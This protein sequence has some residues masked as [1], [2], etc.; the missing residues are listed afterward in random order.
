MSQD[1]FSTI[2]VATSGTALAAILND[3]KDALVSGL[4]GTSR[5]TELDPG[6]MWVDTTLDPASWSLKLWSGASDIEIV[7]I[8]LTNGVASSTL[9]VDAFSVRKISADSVGAIMNLVK[10]RVASNGQVLSGDV[11]G[12]VRVVG[13]TNTS[14]DP[15]VAKI[16]WT[17]GENQTSTTF[18][19]T[20]SFYSTPA[21]TNTLVEHL[22]FAAGQIESVVAH[23]IN[24]LVLA[25]QDVATTATINQ[26]SATKT[27][28]E[29]TGSTATEIRGLNSG[30]ASKVVTIHARTTG[31]G[32]LTFKH[33]NASATA[34]DRFTLPGA[35]DLVV[36]PQASVTFIY[37]TTDSRWKVQA[38]SADFAG[39]TTA[40]L[41]PS[42]SITVPTGVT[43]IRVV[44][45]KSSFPKNILSLAYDG[46]DGDTTVLCRN[47]LGNTLSWGANT[48]GQLADGT[49]V[50]KS[51]PVAVLG[52]LLFSKV[53][54]VGILGYANTFSFGL[55][56]T[57]ALYAWGINGSGQLGVGNVTPRSSPVAVLGGITFRSM[58]F[59]QAG[60]FGLST[61]G[62]A[63]AWGAN[64]SG[65]LGLG[66]STPRS[67]P[68]AVLGG[69][70]FQKLVCGPTSTV[71]YGLTADGT[72]YAW[73]R[74]HRGQLGVG[75]VTDRSSPVQVLG[76][77]RFA[78]V[79]TNGLSSFGITTTGALYAWGFN[80]LATLG[81]GDFNPRSSPVAV[82]G[83]LT[84]KSVISGGNESTAFAA[85]ITTT[86]VAYAW[87]RNNRGQLGVGDLTTRSSPV[88]VLG[89]LTFKSLHNLSGSSVIGLTTSGAL[90]AWGYNSSGELGV[91]NTTT[92][93][94]PV[95]VL[96][97][98]TF[99]DVQ[100]PP[101]DLGAEYVMGVTS[102]GA[103][104]AWGSNFKGQLGV[105]DTTN[106]SSPVAV[107]GGLN[108]GLT[109]PV[110]AMYDI[111]V[112]P[113]DTLTFSA[114][115]EKCFFG[116]TA[117]PDNTEFVDLEY[118]LP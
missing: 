55:A 97:G 3:F 33:E 19:G 36:A 67:S 88:Q 107:L 81:V 32:S 79:A 4:S 47:S 11:V 13:R 93:S 28:V 31:S 72:L 78:D 37:S 54:S 65:S 109:T 6:G 68:V 116:S 56:P 25:S 64:S 73:G 85:G 2:P 42:G 16:I 9:A 92:R 95:Q 24:A 70:T 29:M 51:S 52:G 17:A 102:T 58:H 21:G 105:N 89:G 7:K 48:A 113:G 18:G 49:V 117:L 86:G 30:H 94:S 110:A 23:K 83:G 71:T 43:Q 1:I 14:T 12:E 87:G 53:Y 76:G 61:T 111:T 5:P 39:F 91:G 27:V 40:T 90:Y 22:K 84:F 66:D 34:A 20:L 38:R 35:R 44:A 80:G 8:D 115:V 77:L 63:Y 108:L 103:I 15:V 59:S 96:G 112:T 99:V 118:V 46:V 106:R 82:L 50:A 98:L 69:L 26:L 114:G 57:G 60:V 101:A 100:T 104:Y 62:V 75:D 45:R 74:N 41:T 10:R